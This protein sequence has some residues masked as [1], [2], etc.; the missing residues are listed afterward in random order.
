MFRVRWSFN[1]LSIIAGWINYNLHILSMIIYDIIIYLKLILLHLW[2]LLSSFRLTC[3]WLSGYRCVWWSSSIRWCILTFDFRGLLLMTILLNNFWSWFCIVNSLIEGSKVFILW[4]LD[5][6]SI[7][8][9]VANK[10]LPLYHFSW[11]TSKMIFSEFQNIFCFLDLVLEHSIISLF[12]LSIVFN[13]L[14]SV[15]FVIWRFYISRF[16]MWAMS[17][18][19]WRSNC[20]F[21]IVL[22]LWYLSFILILVVY[23]F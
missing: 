22:I 18:L 3:I 7:T 4:V 9:S 6:A 12:Q 8:L 17:T 11:R 16:S 15:L 23:S 14:L 5:W 2:W 21:K 1:N 19:P 20:A 10:I 13:S